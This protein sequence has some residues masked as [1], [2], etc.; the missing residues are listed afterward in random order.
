[1]LLPPSM[2]VCCGSPLLAL[3]RTA[4]PS[5]PLCAMP[6]PLMTM[7]SD[8][9][10]PGLLVTTIP[11][12]ALASVPPPTAMPIA[13]PLT[14]ELCM[15]RRSIPLDAQPATTLPLTVAL[16]P[17]RKIHHRQAADDA[18]GRVGPQHQ[19]A[20]IAGAGAVYFDAQDGVDGLRSGIRGARKGV[21]RCAALAVAVD[22]HRLVDE[23]QLRCWL[24]HMHAS[25]GDGKVDGV[26]AAVRGARA[27]AE[28]GRVV[29]RGDRFAQGAAV[30]PVDGVAGGGDRQCGGGACAGK[31]T[32]CSGPGGPQVTM[33]DSPL[34]AASRP[35]AMISCA[36]L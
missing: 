18:V 15:P 9:T 34:P 12:C 6:L 24:Y 7:P 28:I 2:V 23:W 27:I 20:R 17:L 21:H 29:D 10:G 13:L 33:H 4:M 35:V 16:L 11:N 22:E 31:Q 26:A 3:P 8:G 25:A 19:P 32:K 30:C 5:M 1:M 14:V 36:P